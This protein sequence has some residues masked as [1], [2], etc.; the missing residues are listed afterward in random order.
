MREAGRGKLIRLEG[1]PPI[2]RLLSEV[3][4]LRQAFAL[5][6]GSVETARL[7]HSVW[8]AAKFNR[9]VLISTL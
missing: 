8:H 3:E 2:S 1:N 4:H 5:E 6:R 9:D 7:G